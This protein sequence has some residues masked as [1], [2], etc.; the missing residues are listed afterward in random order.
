L[1]F[2]FNAKTIPRKSN[3]HK[4]PKRAATRTG[5]L[6]GKKNQHVRR[7]LHGKLPPCP[8]QMEANGVNGNSEF[9]RDLG[10]GFPL[11]E[12]QGDFLLPWR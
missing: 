6:A 2:G 11:N 8:A 12:P 9:L 3:Q 5:S 4:L 10:A 7:R 1:V